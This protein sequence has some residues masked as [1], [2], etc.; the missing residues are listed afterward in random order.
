MLYTVAYHATDSE[1]LWI[2]EGPSSPAPGSSESDVR[3]ASAFWCQEENC[4]GALNEGVLVLDTDAK[5]YAATATYFLYDNQDRIQ[6]Y[7]SGQSPL[8]TTFGPAIPEPDTDALL[9]SGLGMLAFA[10]RWRRRSGN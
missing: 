7:H 8:F 4:G 9:L 1:L 2:G 10:R 5:A 3:V 6:G